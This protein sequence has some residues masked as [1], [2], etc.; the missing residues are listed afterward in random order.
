MTR[1]TPRDGV[2]KLIVA[3][4]ASL[5]AGAVFAQAAAPATPAKPAAP[6]ASSAAAPQAKTD[7]KAQSQE[8]KAKQ[9]S[10][11][12]PQDAAKAAKQ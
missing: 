7:G 10:A 1:S 3:V 9:K 5:I 8:K 4:A 2:N 12:A 6:A 11:T